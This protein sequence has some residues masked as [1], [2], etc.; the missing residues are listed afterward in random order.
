M[1]RL[2][3][4]SEGRGQLWPVV[5]PPGSDW[6]FLLSV[7]LPLTQPPD[8]TGQP[9]LQ[10]TQFQLLN[11]TEYIYL[12]ISMILPLVLHSPAAVTFRVFP[13]PETVRLGPGDPTAPPG[14]APTPNTVGEVA[15]ERGEQGG[16]VSMMPSLH[17]RMVGTLSDYC[18]TLAGLSLEARPVR[19]VQTGLCRDKH[20]QAGLMFGVIVKYQH[21]ENQSILPNPTART[22]ISLW[23]SAG[24]DSRPSAILFMKLKLRHE[25]HH[26]GCD[27]LRVHSKHHVH[28]HRH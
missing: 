11:V 9:P 4:A 27:T 28:V 26:Q 1:Y 15:P 25:P 13:V 14:A 3:I 10:Q 23:S 18:L 21:N 20:T 2:C 7:S 17:I 22:F 6:R 19:A 8:R 12:S 16:V 5:P 24:R